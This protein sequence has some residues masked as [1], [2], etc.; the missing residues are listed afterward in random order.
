MQGGLCRR[1]RASITNA[2]FD[3]E[4]TDRFDAAPRSGGPGGGPLRGPLRVEPSVFVPS[5]L[6]AFV[7]S[8]F[9]R[10]IVSRFR[11]FVVSPSGLSPVV[12]DHFGGAQAALGI[13]QPLNHALP[14]AI[15]ARSVCS[16]CSRRIT[17]YADSSTS[18]V[19]TFA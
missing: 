8:L 4:R 5:C 2:R 3:G 10:F 15:F 7:A 1:C 12:F 17:L 13:A 18:T 11:G 9:R 6:R 16:S 19:V 14:K